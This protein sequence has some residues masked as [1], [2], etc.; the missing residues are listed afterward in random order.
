M[1]QSPVKAIEKSGYTRSRRT[2]L[3]E[4]LN[5]T[6]ARI[7]ATVDF[8]RSPLCPCLDT[9]YTSP[10]SPSPPPSP[11]LFATLFLAEASCSVPLMPGLSRLKRRR[12]LSYG[13]VT[14][15]FRRLTRGVAGEFSHL[16]SVQCL[17]LLRPSHHPRDPLSTRLDSARRDSTATLVRARARPHIV[18][19]LFTCVHSSNSTFLLVLSFSTTSNDLRV[20]FLRDRGKT[21]RTYIQADIESSIQ[22]VTAD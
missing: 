17:C 20:R 3:N 2:T 18:F 6:I 5:A 11:R 15:Q 7:H 22:L 8:P 13:A 9:V 4:S 14:R 12:A 10:P 16:T 1:L 19:F 21:H